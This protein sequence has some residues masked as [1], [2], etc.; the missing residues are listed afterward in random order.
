MAALRY[1]IAGLGLKDGAAFDAFADLLASDSAKLS[2]P[3][4]A[5]I[6]A[7]VHHET[8]GTFRPIEERGKREY[9]NKYEGRE[10]LGN[11]EP[12]DGYLFRGRGYV[13]LTG[14]TNYAKFGE[15]LSL[16]LVGRPEH[17]CDPA[18]AYAILVI[19][20]VK[21]LFTGVGLPRYVKKGSHQEFVQA[22]RVINGTDRAERIAII[23]DVFMK[24]LNSAPVALPTF[25]AGEPM[26]K[27][28]AFQPAPARPDV[29]SLIADVEAALARLK[30]ALS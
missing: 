1:P 24:A 22:R 25:A 30:L 13:Q 16:D 21:G 23:A 12:G 2:R 10:D 20:M 3:W 8:A 15:L 29:A 28:A 27:P 7:T 4:M 19:G 9:F 5:Y 18:T 6:L 26:D 17:A 11:S 14:R